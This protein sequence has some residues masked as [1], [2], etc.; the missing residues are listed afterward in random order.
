MKLE[1]SPVNRRWPNEI[2][3]YSAVPQVRADRR[4][5]LAGACDPHRSA[6]VAL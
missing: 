1:R 3:F 6:S 4:R 2:G 5:R